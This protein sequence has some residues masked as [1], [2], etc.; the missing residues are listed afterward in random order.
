SRLI[1]PT[2]TDVST[3]SLHDALPI[4]VHP[5]FSVAIG[6]D[7]VV[8]PLMANLVGHQIIDISVCG[9]GHV[10]DAL[11]DHDQ[12]AALVAVPAEVGLGDRKSTRLNSSHDQNSYA[13][14]C[15]K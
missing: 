7:H 3:L 4:F 13:V 15:L 6:A 2:P 5:G 12:V 10:E 11:V 14:V 8:P 1:D 9:L